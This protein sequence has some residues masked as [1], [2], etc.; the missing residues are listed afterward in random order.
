VVD[1]GAALTPSARLLVDRQGAPQYRSESLRGRQALPRKLHA[2]SEE[3]APGTREAILDNAQRLFEKQGYD[4]TS[5]RQIAE[6]VGTT[7]AALYYHFPAKEHLLLE[8]TRPMIDE[9]STLVTSLRA[10]PSSSADPAEA[11]A[12]YLDLFLSHL[13]VVALMARDPATQNHPDIGPRLRT[14][15]EALQQHLAGADPTPARFTRTVCALGVIHGAVSLLP[16]DLA[17]EQRETV[18]AAAEAALT[19]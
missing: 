12:A 8:L 17:V 2:V 3:I 11:L 1:P 18:L 15:I 14:L 7:K 16:P 9:L 19:A 4:A 6:A 13:P 5:L 10:D